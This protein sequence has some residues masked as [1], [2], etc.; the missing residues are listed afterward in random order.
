MASF[1]GLGLGTARGGV[2]SSR[3][4]VYKPCWSDG[5][6]LA[7]ILAAFDAAISDGVDIISVSLGGDVSSPYFEDPVAIGAFHAMQKG[8]LTSSSAGNRGPSLNTLDNFAPWLLSVGAH[9]I[10]R[11]I[12]TKVQLGNGM[13]FEPDVTAPGVHV[14][15]AHSP[16]ASLTGIV[17][18]KRSVPFFMLSG[19]SMACPH[20]TAIA[21]YVK[22]FYPTWSEAAIRSALM[23][24]ALPM[25]SATNEEAELAYGSGHINPL[26]AVDPGLVYDAEVDD[27][28]NFLCS[29]GFN[30]TTIRLITRERSSC[31]ESNTNWDLNYPSIALPTSI[32][33]FDTVFT[34]TVTNVGSPYS[35]YKAIV[36]TPQGQAIAIK[37]QPSVLSFNSVGQKL[38]FT[39]RVYGTIG[40]RAL[41]SASL[42]WDDGQHQ[43]RSPIVVFNLS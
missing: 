17:G 15:A 42:V 13:V 20:A 29:Q 30:D 34:R 32:G 38:S 10:D 8:I 18:D 1:L 3:I 21:A 25:S 39:V 40:M 4:A 11:K 41:M 14:L 24:T 23:T 9:T 43:V 31:K 37:V 35:T 22:S 27:Y 7:D 5:C 6:Y 26:K 33:P 2:P 28:V 16:V 12:I 19:T 36:T